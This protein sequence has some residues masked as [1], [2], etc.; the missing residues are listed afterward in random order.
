MTFPPSPNGMG[1]AGTQGRGGGALPR[2]LL[3]SCGSGTRGYERCLYFM[4]YSGFFSLYELVWLPTEF[5]QAF[6]SHSFPTQDLN[7]HGD[8]A[9]RG[10]SF[11]H[12]KLFKGF[13]E[14]HLASPTLS[15]FAGM[16][17]CRLSSALRVLL[18]ASGSRLTRQAPCQTC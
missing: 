9:R 17:R 3:G 2:Q 7:S 12:G 15:R 6:S 4:V 18:P 10:Q 5:T 13:K 1:K 8:R 11:T 16:G 14:T